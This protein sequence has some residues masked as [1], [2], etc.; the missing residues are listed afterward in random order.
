VAV[1]ALYGFTAH[2][3]VGSPTVVVPWA[4]IAGVA[5][6]VPLCAAAVPYLLTRS[7]L[8]LVRRAD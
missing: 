7:R 5:V 3:V 1:G 4:V 8:E 6:L 2:S